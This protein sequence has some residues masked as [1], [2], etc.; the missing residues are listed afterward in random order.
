VKFT[1][2]L[3]AG[4][5]LGN[6]LASYRGQDAVVI[7]MVR[8][9]AVVAHAVAKVLSLPFGVLVVKKI[10]SPANP[11]LAIGAIAPDNIT[12]IHD[13]IARYLHVTEEYIVKEVKR[14]SS[15]VDEKQRLY[16]TAYQS[17]DIG[18]KTVILVDD[19][20][21][22]GASMEAAI[23]WCREQKVK[24]VVVAVPVSPPETVAKFSHKADRIVVI[25]QPEYFSAVGQFYREFPQVSDKEVIHLLID[26]KMVRQ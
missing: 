17:K 15:V 22:T 16:Q 9:G 14:L 7:G 26:R 13:D 12:F 4:T 1:N 21:A 18:Q 24:E 19:G 20:I 8:G 25:E 3:E 23:A 10:P 5:L 2:R 11:E 6:L